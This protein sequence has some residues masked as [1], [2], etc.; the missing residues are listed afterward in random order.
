[1]GKLTLSKNPDKGKL[2]NSGTKEL[3]K[4]RMISSIRTQS[5]FVEL[6]QINPIVLAS[7]E[8]SIRN[9]GFDNSQVLHIWVEKDILLDGHTRLQAAKNSD[10]KQVPVYEHSFQSESEALEYAISLQ[11]NR[12]NLT[13][14]EMMSCLSQLDILK[15]P[16]RQLASDEA[17]SSKGKS[18]GVTA[19]LL[20]TSRS[21]IEKMRSI[22]K[23]GS[24]DLIEEIH[25]GK[26]S[27]NR[28]YEES[29]KKNTKNLSSPSP[30][31]SLSKEND[32]KVS[33]GPVSTDYLLKVHENTIFLTCGD[34]CE[35]RIPLVTIHPD[36][37][38]FLKSSKSKLINEVYD[39]LSSLLV[40]YQLSITTNTK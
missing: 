35:D 32:Q 17:N 22:K 6:F 15:E 2:T 13:D 20:G 37:P 9:K 40:N 38:I 4:M 24:S 16:G 1:M 11:K 31:L 36:N 26:K 28:A 21:K 25:D 19:E 18:A 29:R 10:L 7:I 23:H 3:A 30:L 33:G 34:T 27:I 14:A 5:P 39:H 8:E 12:R